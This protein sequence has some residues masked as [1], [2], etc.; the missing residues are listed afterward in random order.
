MHIINH[1]DHL[2]H[3]EHFTNQTTFNKNKY[4]ICTVYFVIL[5]KCAFIFA[6]VGEGGS[7]QNDDTFK[8]LSGWKGYG[9]ISSTPS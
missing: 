6:I 7:L 4:R 8:W 2:D 5:F 1:L 9:D 3:F